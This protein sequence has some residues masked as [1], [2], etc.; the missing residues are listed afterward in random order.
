MVLVEKVLFFAVHQFSNEYKKL[1]VFTE[2]AQ[3]LDVLLFG[4]DKRR[5]GQALNSLDFSLDFF[6]DLWMI[7]IFF[8]HIVQ[9][10]EIMQ[11]FRLK[12][13]FRP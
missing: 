6:L 3:F 12:L 5:V 9:N 4:L 11:L 13:N 7:G 8:E 10:G 2:H 1:L